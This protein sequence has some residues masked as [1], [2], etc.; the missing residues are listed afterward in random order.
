MLIPLW[1]A[2]ATADSARVV[3]RRVIVEP[4]GISVEM[5]AHWFPAV[6]T[7]S[8]N[9]L[10]GKTPVVFAPPSADRSEIAPPTR[11]GWHHEYGTVADA[12]L[13]R[14]SVLAHF[15]T[16]DWASE[17][18]WGDLQARIYVVDDSVRAMIDRVQNAGIAAANPAFMARSE[19]TD[20]GGGWL[21]ARITW[22]A[23]YYDFGSITHMDYY[24]RS[25]RG[26][27][28]VLLMM[29]TP[30]SQGDLANDPARVLQ[31]FRQGP[32]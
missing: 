32:P 31:S 14:S 2:F 4:I 18:C 12:V 13:P 27:T 6:K 21:R 24:L 19:V 23:W 29:F 16:I 1:L 5:P 26:R 28:V 20:A 3:D 22:D 7:G 30:Y 11:S 25:V 10:E 9:C 15:G 17:P 8:F